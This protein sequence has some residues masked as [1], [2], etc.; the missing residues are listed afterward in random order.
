MKYIRSIDNVL[1]PM[2]NL[3]TSAYDMI[4]FFEMT[5]D[6]VCIA[7]RNGY[8]RNVNRSVLEKLEYTKEE[9]LSRPISFYIHPE[10]RQKTQDLRNELLEGNALINFQ[11]RYVSKTGKVIWLEWTS[12][13]ISDKELVFAIAKDITQK[14]EREKAIEEK[15]SEYK[16]LVSYFKTSLEKE[17]KYL[18]VELHEELAQLASVAKMELHSLY[19]TMPVLNKE[20]EEQFDRVINIVQILLNAIRRITYSIGSKML[21]DL[22]FHQTM[23]WYCQEFSILN[24]IPCQFRSGLNDEDLSEEMQ[25]DFLRIC[26]EAFTNITYHAEAG[27]VLVRLEKIDGEIK[28]SIS[29]NGKGFD[30]SKLEET[31][32]LHSMMQR[33]KSLH[34]NFEIDSKPMEGT[35][36]TVNAPLEIDD[37]SKVSNAT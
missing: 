9:L 20:Q 22:G 28:L 36:I 31:S 3:V 19:K 27:F 11:N 33:A 30:L 1:A 18:A 16:S 29:D 8:F 23:K 24:R 32:G 13:Y 5:P 12:I 14:K 25:I 34:G 6:L 37:L 35:R 10:D 15:Y 17:R 26:Q 4:T 21:E 2:H 7:D